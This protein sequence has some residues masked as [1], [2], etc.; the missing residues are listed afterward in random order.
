MMSTFPSLAVNTE[1]GRKML[2][3]YRSEMNKIWNTDSHDL[4]SEHTDSEL[5]CEP[6]VWLNMCDNDPMQAA[7]TFDRIKA[8]LMIILRSEPLHGTMW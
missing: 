1:E 3:A 8:D 2:N 4:F 7:A 5:T 6:S